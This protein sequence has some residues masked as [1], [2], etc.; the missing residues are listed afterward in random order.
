MTHYLPPPLYHLEGYGGLV[1]L[2]FSLMPIN[3]AVLQ[4]M[5]SVRTCT[6]DKISAT[7]G[8][9]CCLVQKDNRETCYFLRRAFTII[10]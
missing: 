10:K 1:L 7:A 9:F 6:F 5:Q 2:A 3:C 8:R 4:P